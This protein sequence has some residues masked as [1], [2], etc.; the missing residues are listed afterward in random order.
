MGG[1][2]P[3]SILIIKVDVSKED[4]IKAAFSQGAAKF[5]RIDVVFNNAGY[6]MMAEVEG[7]PEDKA[8]GMFDA[9]FW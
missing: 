8:R 3:K 2:Y 9:N 5:G 1:Q 6:G 7:A 4:D